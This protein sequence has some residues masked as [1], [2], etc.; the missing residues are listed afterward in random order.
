MLRKLL[1]KVEDGRFCR[2]MAGLQAGWEFEVRS[3]KFAKTGVEIDGFVKYSGK[4]YSVHIRPGKAFCNCEDFMRR[5]VL[6]KHV[7]FVAMAEL[8]L[9]AAERSAHRQ[10]QEVLPT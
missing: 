1:G 5:Q 10:V 7:A 2:A 9:Y 8:A 4:K 6:C 3:R